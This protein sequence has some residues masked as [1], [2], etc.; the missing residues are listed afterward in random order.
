MDY[1]RITP[2]SSVYKKITPLSKNVTKYSDERP[3]ASEAII[4]GIMYRH[5]AVL[6]SALSDKKVQSK[7]DVPEKYEYDF[8]KVKNAFLRYR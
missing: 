7:W 4:P 3:S 2:K 5:K 1:K 6:K 8:K